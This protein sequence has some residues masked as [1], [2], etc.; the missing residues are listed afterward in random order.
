MSRLA[1]PLPMPAFVAAALLMLAAT[2]LLHL[3]LML[4]DHI[5]LVPIYDAWRQGDLAGSEF[6]RIHD[7]S[8]FHSAAYAVLLLTTWLSDGR[9]WLDCT[10]AW[11]ILV[12]QAWLLMRIAQ[13]GWRD[14]TVGAGWWL[15][16]LL[17]AFHPGHLVNLQWGWQ[18]AVFI[19]L[20]GAVA[21]IRFL[22]LARPTQALNLL[23]L[24]LATAGVLGFTTTLAVFPIAMALIAMRAEWS[25]P[26]RLAFGLPWLVVSM[27][28]IAW[29]ATARGQPVPWPGMGTLAMYVLNYLGGGVLRFAEGLAPAWTAIALLTAALATLHAKGRPQRWPWLALMLF[30]LGC[31]TLTALGRAGHFGADHAFVVRYVS[32][33]SLF[34][35]GW[36]GLMV[37]AY[38]DAVPA[39]R[40]W[41]RP[42]LAVTLVF[43]AGNGL[44]TIKQAWTA[45]E[46]ALAYAAHLRERH[47]DSDP[48]VLEQA[49][50]GRAGVAPERLE[51]LREL[52]F[53]PFG[54][55]RA[56]APA[57][58]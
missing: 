16:A 56:A 46:R 17:L 9:P 45:H 24:L 22:T 50:R 30:A 2:L 4:W 42:L 36:L 44:H 39:W 43:A 35:F 41:A 51:R 40:R 18:V 12:V 27:A 47:P 21:P 20:L 23:G 13:S 58:D 31:A 28:L 5:D 52:G 48:A 49:Y 29:L 15:A 19:S 38:R 10:V 11:S 32:F 3:P 7:G 25:W 37:L 14:A 55:S 53:A 26:R 57:A 34:W 54:E 6:W 8:H 1:I 33:A